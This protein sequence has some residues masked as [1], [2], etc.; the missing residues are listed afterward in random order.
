M[1]HDDDYVSPTPFSVTLHDDETLRALVFVYRATLESP[2][3]VH[4]ERKRR[5]NCI[6][7]MRHALGMYEFEI[8]RRSTIL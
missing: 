4:V 6:K 8:I 1:Q 2:W 5:G 7:E 3:C